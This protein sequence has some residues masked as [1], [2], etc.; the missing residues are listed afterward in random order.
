MAERMLIGSICEMPFGV[1]TELSRLL[2][3]HPLMWSSMI[4]L[5]KVGNAN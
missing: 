5:C 3:N 2:R 4:V 1:R